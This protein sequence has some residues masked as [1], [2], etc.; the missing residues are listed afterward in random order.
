[1]PMP[2]SPSVNRAREPGSLCLCGCGRPTSIA[3]QTDTAKGWVKGRAVM[4]IRGHG[5]TPRGEGTKWC[6]RCSSYKPLAEF[7][8]DRNRHD[9][10]SH[11][12]RAC[13]LEKN[14]E[15][16]KKNPEKRKAQER[17]HWIKSA[18]GLSVREYDALIAKGCAICGSHEHLGIDHDHRN[19]KVRAALCRD[20]NLA[21]GRLKDDPDLMRRAADYV[22]EWQ[23]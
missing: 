18:Y 14:A 1:M 20:C 15:W 2:Q 7:N 4:F 17:R 6:Y 3:E 19:G 16:R 5:Q 21:I 13:Q 11:R 23:H 22:A 9:G 10:L 12:C 8:R